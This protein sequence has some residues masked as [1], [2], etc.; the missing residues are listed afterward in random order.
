MDF[1]IA[2]AA[3][4]SR[5][6]QTGTVIGTPEYM[7]PEQ[8][9]GKEVTAQS[10]QYG[11]GVVLYECITGR[12]PFVGD[13]PLTILNKVMREKLVPPSQIV[14][15]I[16]EW[17]DR[18]VSKAMSKDPQR[19]YDSCGEF[20]AALLAKKEKGSNRPRHQSVFENKVNGGKS[21]VSP[22]MNNSI[23]IAVGVLIL[24]LL[25][26]LVSEINQDSGEPKKQVDFLKPAPQLTE[27]SSKEQQVSQVTQNFDQAH[28]PEKNSN[29]GLMA[30]K[31][32]L[33]TES[34]PSNHK[35]Q[36]QERSP[37]KQPPLLKSKD[38][39]TE[40]ARVE[41]GEFVM[42]SSLSEGASSEHPQHRVHLKSFYM[43]KCEVTVAEYREF[44]VA[45]GRQ[46]PVTPRWGWQDNYPIVNV[47][48]QDANEYAQ[49]R[50]KRLPT[51]AEWEYAAR[52]GN[53]SKGYKYS[54]S[55]DINDVAWY[56]ENSG[57]QPHPVGTKIA[58][59]L[60]I[61]DMSGN[62]WE[63]CS[64]RYDENY[65]SN[66][67]SDNPQGPSSGVDRVL[68]GG[69]WY[70]DDFKCRVADRDKVNP[71]NWYHYYGFR[72]AKD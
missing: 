72:C 65:Y 60:G 63:W 15:N 22:V 70:V 36:K 32:Q 69:S 45:T 28:N 9:D 20:G 41:G 59:E 27:S 56:E 46:M 18:V 12:V 21:H 58:N 30:E 42:G 10:D 50:Q 43:D 24:I 19:R 38:P 35:A 16:P 68:R 5:L 40:M 37:Q 62:V 33:K 71:S 13:N 64:D 4:G 25:I 52:G 61:Y 1:G 17:L 66:S 51:E 8:A 34:P 53:M 31:A 23:T 3:S 39:Y 7:S 57:S 54:G 29:N 67:D 26:I 14:A 48:W 2:H 55:N 49:W 47:S 11:L 44:C 6:T